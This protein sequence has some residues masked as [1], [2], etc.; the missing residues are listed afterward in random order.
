MLEQHN[1]GMSEMAPLTATPPSGSR[2]GGGAAGARRIALEALRAPFTGRASAELLSCLVGVPLGIGGFIVVVVLLGVTAVLSVTLVGTIPGLLLLVGVLALARSLGWLHRELAVRLLGERVPAPLPRRR[3]RGALG[4]LGA[5]LRDVTAWRSLA[6]LVIKLPLS[7]LAAYAVSFWVLG[8][9]NCS[10]PIWWAGFR[11]HPPGTTLS[12][13]PVITLLPMGRFEVSTYAGTFAALAVGLA[14][15][16]LAPWVTRVVVLADR[17]LVRTL[18]GPGAME[19]RV[20]ALEETRALAVD[21]SAATLRRLERD[22]HDG[23][24]ARLVALAMS[25]GMA[26]EK[27]GEGGV[28]PDADR[29]RELV[30]SAHQTA[31]EAIAELRDLA[32]GIHPPALDGGLPDALATLAARSAVSV[33]LR[34]DV[35]HRPTA[36]IETIAYFCAA[37]LLTN[38]LRHSGARHASIEAGE[39]DGWLWL[40]VRDDGAGGARLG[41]GSGLDGLAQR[42][43]TV[44]GSM[45]VTSPAGGP[46][47]VVVELPMHA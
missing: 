39:R 37:E 35:P 43:R 19:A 46:T 3:G 31:T 5:A 32:R 13:V 41:A 36:A 18:L 2:P 11:N 27:L 47:E 4:R 16:L 40:R 21:D 33:D 26:R 8:L 28:E 12:P 6:Y 9:V 17:W 20:R 29:A 38:V 7:L 44:D 22:L 34:V 25:L 24:Q 1:V 10:Y 45:T 23:T 30:A 14:T 15:V 42:V